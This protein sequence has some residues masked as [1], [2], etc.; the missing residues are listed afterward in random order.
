MRQRRAKFSNNPIQTVEDKDTLE[1]RKEKFGI[2]QKAEDPSLVEQRKAKFGGND[3]VLDD[4]IDKAKHE[5]KNNFKRSK[6]K[7]NQ[8]RNKFDFNNKKRRF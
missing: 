2:V 8:S 1:K 7:F 6:P 5:N 4:L 3:I